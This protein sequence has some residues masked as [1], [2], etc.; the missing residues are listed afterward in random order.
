MLQP[1]GSRIADAS[2][3]QTLPS[4]GNPRVPC[5]QVRHPSS[6]LSGHDRHRRHTSLFLALLLILYPSSHTAHRG[7]R[8]AGDRMRPSQAQPGRPACG[9][10]QTLET[11][12]PDL[13][14]AP[15]GDAR[16]GS[17]SV[18]AGHAGTPSEDTC[19]RAPP[20]PGH[21]SSGRARPRLR[22]APALG[23]AAGSLAI[24]PARPSTL[25]GVPR[26]CCRS[27][28]APSAGRPRASSLEASDARTGRRQPR[29]PQ[30]QRLANV[31]RALSTHRPRP[32]NKHT[33]GKKNKQ[34]AHVPKGEASLS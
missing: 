13:S 19:N 11:S 10:I 21:L 8:H 16:A 15:L 14:W 12:T 20:N 9:Q 30:G 32:G 28:R 29:P 1:C 25:P 4:Y 3:L 27:A 7:F 17:R 22:K 6:H 18:A 23:T 31:Q 33:R 5:P 2:L 34:T 24:L 26:F